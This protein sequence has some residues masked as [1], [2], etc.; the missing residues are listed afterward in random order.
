MSAPVHPL[1]E[2]VVALGDSVSQG[3]QNV[4]VSVRSQTV[5]VPALLCRQA[6]AELPL[7][8]LAEPGYPPHVDNLRLVLRSRVTHPE[9]L[10][11][12][13]LDP[14]V[15]PRNYAVAGVRLSDVIGLTCANMAQ[16]DRT[17]AICRLTRLV[18]NPLGRPEWEHLSQLD[19]A[20]AADPSLVLLWAGANDAIEA[21]F[22]P[23]YG[24]TPREVFAR[25]WRTA[26][27]RLLA[28]TSAVIVVLTIPDCTL[29]PMLRLWRG[30][31]RLRTLMH[32]TLDEYNAIIRASAA[33]DE[34]LVVVDLEP[35]VNR[36]HRAGVP[37]DGWQ[38]PFTVAGRR[39]TF[40]ALRGVPGRVWSGGLISFD[41]LHPTTT[42]YAV[43]TNVVID[44][45][46]AR[47]A[48]GVP[49]LD[50]AAVARADTILRLPTPYSAAL[51]NFYMHRCYGAEVDALEAQTWPLELRE[52]RV[53]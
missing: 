5:G 43:L 22:Y 42:G 37:V 16:L 15:E 8:L 7:P 10:R 46:N 31:D 33:R 2:R 44:Q 12:Q 41:G 38:V 52:G 48:T 4:G 6:R 19:R 51:L 20:I 26:L 49:R 40:D 50:L 27:D 47:L 17:R 18:L 36:I 28:E 3:T 24:V 23:H 30:R 9:W 14:T 32:R 1:F 25:H 53:R 21:M 39:L 13:R 45:L 34:R 11:G 35:E 29:L